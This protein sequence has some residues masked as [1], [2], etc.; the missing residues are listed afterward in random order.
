VRL[1]RRLVERGGGA[2]ELRPRAI[3]GTR[4]MIVASGSES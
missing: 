4:A 2:L 1:C 3:R